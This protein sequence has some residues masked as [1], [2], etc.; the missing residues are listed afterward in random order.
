MQTNGRLSWWKCFWRLDIINFYSNRI[1][2]IEG[3]DFAK[4]NNR[5]ECMFCHYWF[6]SHGLEFQDSVWFSQF[7]NA[8]S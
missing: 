3:I 1:D 6:F 7:D 8:N 2:I 4:C 5:K